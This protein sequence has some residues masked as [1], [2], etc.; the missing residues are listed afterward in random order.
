MKK[1]VLI[2]GVLSLLFSCAEKKETKTIEERCNLTQLPKDIKLYD[3]KESY[4]Q[5]KGQ[6]NIEYKIKNE[7]KKTIDIV[8][9]EADLYIDGEKQGTATGGGGDIK[10]GEYIEASFNWIL[11]KEVP[12]S[13][14]V[15]R[16]M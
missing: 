7:S 12:D 1:S 11:P 2:I 15:R 6:W 16:T 3:I 9:L 10:K 8:S 13:I 5:Y 14:V 4:N